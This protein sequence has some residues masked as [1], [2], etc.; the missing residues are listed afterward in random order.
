MSDHDFIAA[1][2]LLDAY[3]AGMKGWSPD[4]DEIAKFVGSLPHPTF[5][6]AMPSMMAEPPKDAF[7]W[8]PMR[9]NFPNWRRIA[10]AI[11]DCF[12][13]GTMV[14]G[15]RTKP[16]EEVQVGDRV[17]TAE[18]SLTTVV[19]RREIKTAKPLVEI[20]AVG[21]PPMRCTIDHRLL[22]YR[23]RRFDKKRLTPNMYAAAV[24]G[25]HSIPHKPEVIRRFENRKA[26]WVTAGELVDTDVLL[27]PVEFDAISL[28]G[29]PRDLLATEEGRFVAGYFLG[30]G[31][32]GEGSA[33]WTVPRLELA[34][35][36]AN[37]L[38]SIG[39]APRINDCHAGK[40]AMRVRVHS[41]ELVRWLRNEFYEG[42][43]K[44]FPGWA[45]GDR[46]FLDG[47]YA[48]DGL[49]GVRKRQCLGSTSRSIVFGVVASLASLG[50][51]ASVNLAC[52]SAG[53]YENAKPLWN[54]TWVDNPQRQKVWRDEQY[55]CRPV[56]STR[57][58]EGISVVY[59]IGVAD[60]HHSFIA[61]GIGVHNCVSHGWELSAF[62]LANLDGKPPAEF[63][64]EAWYGGSRVEA[65][66][67]RL[68]G[69]SDGSYGA[70]A[71]KWTMKW[72]ALLRHDYSAQ[73]GDPDH[74]VRVYSGKRAKEWG[75]YGCGGKRDE[76]GNGKLDNIAREHPCSDV[77]L[78]KTVEEAAAALMAGK[79]IAVCSNVG[80]GNMQRNSQGVV[81]ARGNW[82]HCMMYGGVRW[83][84]GEPQF[85]QFQSWGDSCSGDDPGVDDERISACSWWTVAD[86]AARQLRQG[87]SFALA[88]ITGWDRPHVDHWLI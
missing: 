34:E 24:A 35:R 40:S 30:N 48:A 61:N 79:P 12:P 55:V 74:D 44:S 51:N 32:A 64:T 28:P 53:T 25:L 46:H 8:V 59:D 21:M 49:G 84:N 54:V 77:A 5:A 37:Y 1:M 58:I 18:G 11:G 6:D 27:S 23:L 15:E 36:I 76:R 2:D 29:S 66:G 86:D 31:Y 69:Y 68:G 26:E 78:V 19:S 38:T 82:S 10:Q 72:G 52:R 75:N 80:F 88:G 73:T 7:L 17:F 87:D 50:I 42:K 3:E 22:V 20:K 65:R 63:C 43:E 4:H 67:G 39:F 16:I 56:E 47:L 81:R 14:T 83:V 57:L 71:A 62:M 60:Q 13:A 85:R 45:I 33:E 9:K 70:P 41:R